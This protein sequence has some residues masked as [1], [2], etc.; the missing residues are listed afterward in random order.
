M[1]SRQL[2]GLEKTLHGVDYAE[3]CLLLP[4]R[5]ISS[6]YGNRIDC[7]QSRQP[8][9]NLYL[10]SRSVIKIWF[11]HINQTNFSYSSLEI[12]KTTQKQVCGRSY[13]LLLISLKAFSDNHWFE[14]FVTKMRCQE[15]IYINLTT[16]SPFDFLFR[17]K[18]LANLQQIV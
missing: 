6:S 2:N 10:L 11:K 14:I 13:F 17:R 12:F 18:P 3:E 16:H 8:I 9:L 7:L 5:N 1:K 4:E 15:N